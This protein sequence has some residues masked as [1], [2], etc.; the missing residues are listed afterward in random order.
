MRSGCR[1]REDITG[2]GFGAV[3][4]REAR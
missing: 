4:L 2:R 3:R 1:V